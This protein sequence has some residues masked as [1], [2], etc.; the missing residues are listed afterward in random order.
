MI[1]SRDGLGNCLGRVLYE[2][3][4]SDLDLATRVGISR[5]QLNRIRN[6]RA[7]PRVAT[8]IAL[9]AALGC[10]VKDL[11]VLRSTRTR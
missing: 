11:F 2:R 5:A 4:L 9:A 8:A 3:G 7:V 10:R 1:E 6:G